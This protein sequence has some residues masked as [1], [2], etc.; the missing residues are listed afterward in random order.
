[1]LIKLKKVLADIEVSVNEASQH[2]EIWWALGFTENRK[3]YQDVF[4]H[5]DFNKFLHTSYIANQMAMFMALSR[6]FDSS[7]NTSSFRQLKLLLNNADLK[8]LS[9]YIADNLCIHQAVVKK[10][11]DIR[12]QLLAH[13]QTNQQD[14]EVLKRN[15][16]KPSE[17]KALIEAAQNILVK[18][19]YDLNVY[20][21]C[22]K[23]GFHNES[24]LNVLAKLKI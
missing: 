21:L 13:T 17:I 16:I 22:Y 4:E 20:N 9:E 10:I 14:K 3:K 6:A 11:L 8:E 23:K 15:G 24:T 1:M 19:S 7:T 5:E 2:C 12:C 18:I